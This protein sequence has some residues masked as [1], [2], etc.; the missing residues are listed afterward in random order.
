MIKQT[1]TI[2]LTVQLSYLLCGCGSGGAK[3]TWNVILEGHQS[4][5]GASN[6]H[7]NYSYVSFTYNGKRIT[8]CGNWIAA[9]Q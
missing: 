6:L 7:W 5:L 8:V 1:L 2:L 3:Q 4:Y 9:E